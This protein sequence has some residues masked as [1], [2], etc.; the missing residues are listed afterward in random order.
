MIHILLA[1]LLSLGITQARAASCAPSPNGT[2]IPNG[3]SAVLLDQACNKWTVAGGV[4]SE[5]GALAGY[6]AN[7][8]EL[9][10][11]GT[12]LWQLN[13]TGQWWGSLP[14]MW[15]GPVIPSPLPVVAAAPV[16]AGLTVAQQAAVA[17]VTADLTKL[18]ADATTDGNDLTK[19]QSD[20]VAMIAALAQ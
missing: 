1:F 3:T 15:T 9:A 18:L 8:I 11:V 5:N 20:Y 10:I 4:V 12:E 16:A 7:V 14:T 13:T 19:F 2:M 6:T 17:L